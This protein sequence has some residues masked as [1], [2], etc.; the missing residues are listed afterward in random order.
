MSRA[1]YGFHVPGG[2]LSPMVVPLR[3]LQA[4]DDFSEMSAGKLAGIR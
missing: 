3:A 1:R 4:F 2:E